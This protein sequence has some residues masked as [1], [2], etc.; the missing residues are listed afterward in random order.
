DA[1]GAAA[2]AGVQPGD[3]VLAVNGKPVASVAQVRD[4]VKKSAKSV[5]LLV[6]R[7]DEKIFIPVP[8]S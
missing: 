4:V 8:I 5:A 1:G 6:Q 3:V 7:G 2:V